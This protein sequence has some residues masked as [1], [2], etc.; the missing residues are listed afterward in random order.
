MSN[1]PSPWK[2]TACILCE[3]N[4][5]LEVQVV[6]RRLVR[7][8]GDR[9]H[10]TSQ[11]YACEKPHRLDHYQNATDRLTTPLRRR[12]DG[13]FEPID[14]DTAIAE[15]AGHL[16]RIRD[17]HGG[18]TIF[19]YGGGGQGNHLPGA[20]GT[21]TRRAL[22]SRYRSSALAQEKT[23]EFWVSDQML[24]GYTR[25]DFEHAELALFIGKN[26]WHS[27]SIARA[28]VTL[29]AIAQDPARKMIVVDP[30]R[31]ETAELADLHLQLRPGTDAWLLSAMVAVLIEEDLV[32]HAFLG[33]HAVG[34][35]AV[36]A[37][38]R[39]VPIAEYA[40]IADV[41]EADVRR[42]AR[43]IAEAKSVASA[44]DLGVQMNLHSTFVSYLHR[45][46]WL[47]TGNLGRPGTQYIP[48]PLVELA[49]GRLKRRSPVVGAPLIGELVPCNVIPDEIL[50][51]H[52][53]RYRAM[54]VEGANPAHSLAEAAR[55]QHALQS[56]E[57]L[58]V[59]DV[60]MSETAQLAHY[61]LPATSQFEKAEA[62]FFN[63]E[64]PKNAFHL[65]HPV[66][67][68]PEGPLP[69]PEIHA[70]LVEA[71]GLLDEALVA[72]LSAAAAAGLDAF[73]P[74]FAQK[75]AFDPAAS[76][77]AAVLLYRALGPHLPEGLAPSAVLWG[78]ALRRAMESP[79]ALARAGFEGSPL[80]VANRLFEAI[81]AHPSGV[82][83]AVDT[84]ADV[85]ARLGTADKK[86]HLALEPLL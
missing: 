41:P 25:G 52:P 12:P 17:A 21:A 44:E 10:P 32:D 33:E 61:V 31:T 39:E 1:P 53:A 40:A 15:V 73:A 70:R 75:V 85:M 54:I 46:L 63:T 16:A 36:Q 5:G 38:F 14:W 59:I 45:L 37:A 6:G 13:T 30:R 66:L 62:T 56:L 18:E 65:R 80:E 22:G 71:L 23:G 64:F 47:L 27:H 48:L 78:L 28:R 67:T 49:S 24:G 26:P 55:M 84:W 68:P 9:A 58:V 43:L 7:F 74:V 2:P 69:E 50:T 83:F 76:G 29:K 81:L 8:R 86:V 11:G 82:V 4:C 60:A 20:Y 57:C 3:C 35:E 51:D 34:F 72:E 79:A 77:L 19:Y 42:A